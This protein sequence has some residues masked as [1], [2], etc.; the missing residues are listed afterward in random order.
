MAAQRVPIDRTTL[1]RFVRAVKNFAGSEVRGRAALLFG[2]LLSLLI[3]INAL[4]VVNSYVGRDL[5]TAIE[6]RDMHAFARQALLYVGVFALSTL[7]AVTYRFSEER[8]GLLWRQWLTKRLLDRYLGATITGYAAGKT[9]A[10]RTSASPTTP[11]RSS[12]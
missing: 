1:G 7:A 5:M 8:L 10:T 11:V 3:G 12:R 2:I 4:N 6:R 9:W